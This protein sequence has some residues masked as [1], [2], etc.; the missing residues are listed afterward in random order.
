M[1][2]LKE[3]KFKGR[4]FYFEGIEEISKSTPLI[5]KFSLIGSR[6]ILECGKSIGNWKHLREIEGAVHS[7]FDNSSIA[8]PP[9]P[10]EQTNFFTVINEINLEKLELLNDDISS[11]K[12]H[13]LPS[14]L[15]T[16]NLERTRVSSKLFEAISELENL[17]ILILDSTSGFE[18]EDFQHLNSLPNLEELSLN[19]SSHC[20]DVGLKH[21]SAVKSLKRVFLNKCE[22]H[23]EGG[24]SLSKLSNLEIIDLQY[25]DITEKT[26]NNI[27]QNCKKI[28]KICVYKCQKIS[29]NKIADL[30]NIKQILSENPINREYY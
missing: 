7:Y 1:S 13:K 27:V 15:I 9:T 2:K 5:Q 3:F 16:L 10:Q 20:G 19:K 29:K 11:A 22:I 18:S 6:S 8:T 23:D 25:S 12:F 26:I 21:I 4:N 14:S 28:K 17:K 30:P 24:I